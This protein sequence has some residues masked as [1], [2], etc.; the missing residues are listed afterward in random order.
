MIVKIKDRKEIAKGTLE[1]VFDASG[2][3]LDFKAGQFCQITLINPPHTDNRGNKRFLGFTTSPS[4]KN[5]FAIATKI[6]VSAF[7]KSLQEMP[8]GTGVE[9]G[10]IDGRVNHLPDDLNTHLVFLTQGIG[11][12]P[13]MGLLRFSHEQNWPYKITLI[14]ANED[15][16]S[17]AYFEE[18]ESFTKDNSKFTFIPSM[19]QD[20]NWNGEKRKISADLIKDNL[21]NLNENSYVITGTPKFVP[22]TIRELQ[23]LSIPM[24]NVKMEIF[25]GY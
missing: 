7:K 9:L 18:L 17:A 15:R 10:G 12:A 2:Q 20:D 3:N 23:S 19:T 16:A 25:T 11:I 24:K 5:T 4:D 1:V 8:L 22:P 6:G 13:L 14:Y 21:Q